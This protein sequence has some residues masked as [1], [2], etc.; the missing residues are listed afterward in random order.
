MSFPL[1]S[2]LRYFTFLLPCRVNISS[3]VSNSYLVNFFLYPDYFFSSFTLSAYLNVLRVCSE[4]LF[5]G[6]IF[7]IMT[8]LLFPTRESLRT[9]V[10][11]LPRKGLCDF[12]MS[13]ARMHSLSASKDLLISAPSYLVCL[14]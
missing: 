3:F 11:L 5:E 2:H 1:R 14:H 6:E 7:A 12:F 13:K 9:I 4:E 10:S 8:V